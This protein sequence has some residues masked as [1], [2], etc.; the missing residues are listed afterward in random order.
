MSAT[1]LARAGLAVV[2]V[3]VVLFLAHGVRV[4]DLDAEGQAALNAVPD[5]IPAAQARHIR[6][7]FRDAQ[8]LN[9]DP[10]PLV[11]EAQLESFLAND[12]DAVR[13]L[14]RAVVGSPAYVPAWQ[15]LADV[16]GDV[17]PALAAR[18]RRAVRRLNPPAPQPA[19]PTQPSAR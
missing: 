2:G 6:S 19:A 3:L 4:N 13:L 15:L 7:L 10:Q 5:Q 8:F 12:R 14:R 1:A 16:A 17:D 18:A 9:P 11:D